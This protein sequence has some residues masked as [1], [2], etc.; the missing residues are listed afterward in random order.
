MEIIAC[1]V[2]GNDKRVPEWSKDGVAYYRCTVCSLVFESPRLSEEELTAYYSQQSYFVNADPSGATSGYQNYC[3]QCTPALCDDYFTHVERHAA[4]KAGTYC[5]IGCGAGGVLA[6]AAARGWD[7]S[8]VEISAWAVQ[9]ARR[10]GLKV[11]EGSLPDAKFPPGYYDALSMFD[12]L[13][14]LPDP[15]SYL[16]EARRIMKEGGVLVIETPNVDGFFARHV[17]KANADLVKPRAHISLFGPHSARYLIEKAGFTSFTIKTFPYS[18]RITPG[19]IKSVLVS[20]CM[21]GAK[22]VQITFNDSLRIV[23]RK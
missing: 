9:E 12:V 15:V 22:P 23:C 6:V 8:G 17:Y 10:Q 20:R 5:D 18:R 14:H 21:P 1:P 16:Q 13:E 3:A 2:C 11:F 7:A 19:Y 4:V